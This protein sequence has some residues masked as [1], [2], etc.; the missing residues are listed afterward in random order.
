MHNKDYK[1]HIVA[2]V[3]KYINEHVKEKLTLNRAAEVFSISPNYLSVLF[4]K[5][6]DV[7]FTD[8]VNQRKVEAAKKMMA[9]G[10]MKIYEISDMLGFE[11]AFYFSRV[12][13]KTEGKSPREYMN[14]V[15]D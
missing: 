11:S 1:N 7:G 15:L 14:N 10:S 5:Y 12:F 4:S 13:K 3:K 8:Y 9:D 6:S 2:Q